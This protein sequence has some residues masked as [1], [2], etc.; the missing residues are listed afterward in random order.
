MKHMIK[1]FGDLAILLTLVFAP[2]AAIAM[3]FGVSLSPI[4]GGI[5]LVVSI[6]GL[7][8]VVNCYFFKDIF[9]DI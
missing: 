2:I 4:F 9:D 7:V 8:E 6:I 5:G 1:N 3:I